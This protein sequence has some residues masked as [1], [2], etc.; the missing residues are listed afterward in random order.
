[1]MTRE[2]IREQKNEIEELLNSLNPEEA[3][4]RIQ[5][6]GQVAPADM[7]IISYWCIYHMYSGDAARALEYA[8]QG[9]RRYPTSTEMYYNLAYAYE[10]S[11]DI[12]QAYLC[13]KKS[14]YLNVM[15]YHKDDINPDSTEYN[16]EA[17][18]FIEG[19]DDHIKE[20]GMELKHLY[21]D[22]QDEAVRQSI[23]EVMLYEESGQMS[24]V[25]NML[26]C[27]SECAIGSYYTI[28]YKDRMYVADYRM[29]SAFGFVP[30]DRF[31]TFEM[32]AELRYVTEGTEYTLPSDIEG[33]EYLLPVAVKNEF[34]S[35]EFRQGDRSSTILQASSHHF[36]YYRIAQGTKAVS[37]DMSYYGAPVR[38]GHSPDRKK[39]VISLFVDGLSQTVLNDIKDVMPYTWA[40]FSDGGI[41]CT[42]AHST[43]EWTYPS[44]A[45]FNSGLYTTRHMLF[46]PDADSML[47][48][49]VTLLAEYYKQAGYY[50]SRIGGNWRITPNYGFG[51]GF[52]QIIYRSQY[53]GFRLDEIMGTVIDHI[54]AFED[55]DQF[56]AIDMIDLH[57]VADYFDLP[58]SAQTRL[59]I[60]VRDIKSTDDTS[61]QQKYNPEKIFTYKVMLGCVDRQLKTLYDYIDSNYSRD[62]VVIALFSDH[63]QGYLVPE[64]GF[65]LGPER[66]NVAFMLKGGLQS[67]STYCDELISGTDYTSIMCNLSGIQMHNE[68]IDG[69]LPRFLG[70]PG[71]E[72]VINE[73]L[74]PH[75][76]YKAVLHTG[77][78]IVHF[79]NPVP[80][81]HDGRFTLGDYSISVYDRYTD[82]P[83]DDNEVLDKYLD[84]IL[85]HIEGLLIYG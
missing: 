58:L 13:Y 51:R 46:H 53:C 26:L 59:P 27:G 35:H 28:G 19:T 22:T 38:L 1:M 8:I 72:Y 36:N 63:G 11:G 29:Q 39:L 79:E 18:A 4:D 50:T 71:H 24:C 25:R 10:M 37:G 85:K 31:N 84:I 55:T 54:Y 48:T 14:Y 45:A 3:Y 68:N 67:D 64:E 7:D 81:S 60:N 15:L 5:V 70:G 62:E 82:S 65:F 9:V 20:L 66:T 42:N 73:S 49:D 41:I 56:L 78:Y 44:V 76:S 52:D 32:A 23:K 69:R 16:A 47:P 77:Q 74:H 2:N 75:Q 83:I 33:T 30:A 21:S 57:N 80:V 34:T 17:A 61:V 40:F 43:A 12:I 6:Y